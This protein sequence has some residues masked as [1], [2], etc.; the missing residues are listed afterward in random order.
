MITGNRKDFPACIFD[1][2]ATI[3]L[4]FNQDNH[5]VIYVLAFN[6]ESFEKCN[7]M[8]KESEYKQASKMIG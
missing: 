2:L 1:T 8:L 6:R 7:N 4:E 3:N 5:K